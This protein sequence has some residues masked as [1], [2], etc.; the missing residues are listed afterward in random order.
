MLFLPHFHKKHE[1]LT[2]LLQRFDHSAVVEAV[3][4]ADA[5]LAIN[6]NSTPLLDAV[7]RP[8]RP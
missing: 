8:D 1:S 2:R 5:G 3:R 6:P 7:S 4:M